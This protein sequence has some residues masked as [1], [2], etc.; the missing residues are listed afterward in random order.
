MKPAS[1]LSILDARLSVLCPSPR[2]KTDVP[3][4]FNEWCKPLELACPRKEVE[5][6]QG[7]NGPRSMRPG[8]REKGAVQRV[9][10]GAVAGVLV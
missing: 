1:K 2:S 8:N 7:I 9:Q 3:I 5:E 6:I 4:A 10:V